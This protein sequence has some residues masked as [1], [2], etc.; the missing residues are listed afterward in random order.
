M[1][2]EGHI[3]NDLKE[4]N[5]QIHGT[6]QSV[7]RMLRAGWCS[8]NDFVLFQKLGR[9]GEV[10][11]SYR[12]ANFPYF[13][14]WRKGWGR[15]IRL[16]F[17]PGKIMERVL[18]NTLHHTTQNRRKMLGRLNKLTK[19]KS[20]LAQLVTFPNKITGFDD[21]ITAVD[22]FCLDFS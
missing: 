15:T 14:K 2:D 6:Q 18:W 19:G 1:M 4:L 16:S 13:Q 17:V 8:C 9:Q 11:D 5:W 7:L 20:S 3:K 12:K 22:F 10:C 21:E